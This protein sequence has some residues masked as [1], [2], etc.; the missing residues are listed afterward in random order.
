MTHNQDAAD[1]WIDNIQNQ[2]ELHLLL[3]DKR[4]KWIIQTAVLVDGFALPAV[5]AFLIVIRRLQSLL[6]EKVCSGKFSTALAEVA[7]T[8]QAALG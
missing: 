5:V 7:M 3:P 8:K 2:A 4:G 1:R 6:A